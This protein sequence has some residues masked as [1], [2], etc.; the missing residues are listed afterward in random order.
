M[1]C[2][3]SIYSARII[4]RRRGRV[5]KLLRLRRTGNLYTEARTPP[6]STSKLIFFFFK[7]FKFNFIV[8]LSFMM[9]K[10]YI[11]LIFYTF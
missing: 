11:N 10:L 8:M 9:I 2:S 6:E 1:F 4:R 7:L 3:D 5:V